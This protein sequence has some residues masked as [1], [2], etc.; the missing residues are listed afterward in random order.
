M[1]RILRQPL[2]LPAIAI[3]AVVLTFLGVLG[4][5]ALRSLDAEQRQVARQLTRQGRSIIE[6]IESS[7]RIGMMGMMWG[8][9][10]MQGLFEEIA[11]QDDVEYLHLVEE[12]TGIVRV[13]SSPD[14]VGTKW[15][16]SA[17][18]WPGSAADSVVSGVV[19]LDDGG[20]VFQIAKRFQP[21]RGMRH[22]E[23]MRRWDN[24]CR[25]MSGGHE[26]NQYVVVLGLSLAPY[27]AAQAE[28]LRRAVGV[29]AV[30]L[31]LGA[32]S[33]FFVAVIQK[34][35]VTNRA[36][37]ETES[38]LHNLV[39]SMGHGLISLDPNGKV[40][41]VNRRATEILRLPDQEL[42]GKPFADIM[43]RVR[44]DVDLEAGDI[45]EK[46]IRCSVPSG[47][48]VSVSVTASKIRSPDGEFLGTVLILRDLQEIEALEEK[49]RRSERLASLGQM[50]AGIAHEVRNPLGS[51][52]GLA[53]Y[54]ARKFEQE[55]DERQY[56]EAII[57]ET[58]RLNRV[59][60]DLLDFAR[61]HEPKL[62]PVRMSEVIDHAL[63]LVRADLEGKEI[64]I[65]RNGE[66]DVP[67]FMADPDLLAQVLLNL[68]LNAI[69]A[70]DG[71]GALEISAGVD[72]ASGR[73]RLEVRDNGHGIEPEHLSKI[74]D[75]F[76]TS[77]RGGTG[78][79]LA[80]V[81]R[82]IENHGGSIDV[83]SQPGEGTTF[84]I[85]LPVRGEGGV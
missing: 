34:Y 12:G 45:S 73:I 3:L 50:A 62:Q 48:Q 44:C 41:T 38:Y 85:W 55:P 47:A 69:E 51:I 81:H 19:D 22:G 71:G 68:F 52:K 32:A 11:G 49:V 25:M 60:Q 53:Q 24:V 4:V 83:D 76:F 84:V 14:R 42:L 63:N 58:D 28:D 30:L 67:E 18:V 40:V 2:Y 20:Q 36:L 27:R 70:M 35:Y 8:P 75:P 65:Q 80:T 31:I 78:L 72:Q 61:P 26:I 39:E 79:G 33:L 46:R 5:Y 54:F 15:Q 16:E 21:A 37:V 56:A 66:A 9:S 17:G 7:T 13:S 43:Q 29:G 6:S 10:E 1:K 77:K 74:F 23:M 64:S 59:I 82:I 57:A